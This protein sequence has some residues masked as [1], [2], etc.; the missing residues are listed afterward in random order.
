MGAAPFQGTVRNP[1]PAAGWMI[2]AYRQRQI[3]KSEQ[4]SAMGPP[5][6]ILVGA[7]K[8]VTRQDVN[9]SRA[10]Q[11]RATPKRYCAGTRAERVVG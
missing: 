5:G 6:S 7:S 2:G 9:G 4:Q 11:R 3:K 10:E 1:A 8:T